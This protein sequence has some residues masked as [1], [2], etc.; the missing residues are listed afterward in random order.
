M[1]LWAV[2]SLVDCLPDWASHP[3][4]IVRAFVQ[5]VANGTLL[6]DTWLT[7]QATLLGLAIAGVL[8]ILLGAALGLRAS[9]IAVGLRL[10]L[11]ISLL[12]AVTVEIALDWR[13]G[14][15]HGMLDAQQALRW[16]LLYAQLLWLGFVGWALDRGLRFAE[17]RLLRRRSASV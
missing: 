14:L 2:A 6:R 13:G 3:S 10:A 7:L 5:A 4:D 17:R 12:V 11:A 8:G 16:D 1:V 9:R 15:G